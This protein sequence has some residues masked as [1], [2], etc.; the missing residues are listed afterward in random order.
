M[1]S[2]DDF[3]LKDFFSACNK[4][5]LYKAEDLNFK[6]IYLGILDILGYKSL[7]EAKGDDAPK[8]LIQIFTEIMP[9]VDSSYESLN[10]KIL[11]DTIIVYS[12]NENAISFYHIY[13]VLDKVRNHFLA[14]G[15]LTRGVIVHGKS[16]I[17]DDI[18]I[19]PAFIKAYL[20]EQNECIYPR[21]IWEKDAFNKANSEVIIINGIPGILYRN[22]FAIIDYSQYEKDFDG[23]IIGLLKF[24]NTSI[25]ELLYNRHPTENRI[26][27]K[28]I[29]PEIIN[30]AIR[31]LQ[32]YREAI[33]V[34]KSSV[35][36]LKVNMKIDYIINKYN[37][38]LNK[39]NYL[40]EIQKINL[41]I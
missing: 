31:E 17:K 23:Q 36:C 2:P 24:G 13:E 4:W 21:I 28:E 34:I 5:S 16:F 15:V 39:L 29:I 37:D 11:S 1:Y 19:S 7:I 40:T 12:D 14:K 8:F 41:Q 3:K 6:Y 9:F 20:M 38:L 10:I 33:T 22:S 18:I 35:T 27:E 30:D 32:K 26:L 25:F